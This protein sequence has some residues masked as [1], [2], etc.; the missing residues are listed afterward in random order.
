MEVLKE[1]LSKQAGITDLDIKTA[2][3]FF[4][5]ETLYKGDYF[6]REDNSC[7][8]MGFVLNGILKTFYTTSSEQVIRCF[9]QE[10]QWVGNFECFLNQKDSKE[11]IQALSD[12]TLATV[13]YHSYKTILKG[14]S[15]WLE[16]WEAIKQKVAVENSHN[17]YLQI[18]D[19]KQRYT[20]FI[21]QKP[22]LAI[23]LPLEDIAD[24]LKIPYKT[25]LNILYETVIF[26]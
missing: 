1:Y 6:V 17:E 7:A 11:S 9:N 19:F 12:V 4:R 5:L 2:L 22:E 14:K 10:M 15:D 3:P 21:D 23:Q 18:A 24:Y 20:H 16:K 13:S 26:S 8:K 25:L